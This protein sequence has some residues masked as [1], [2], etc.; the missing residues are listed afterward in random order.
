MDKSSLEEAF[1]I[2]MDSIMGSNIKPQDKIE[3]LM[4]LRNFLDPKDYKEN[5]TILDANK[6]SKKFGGR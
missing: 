3:L 4:N 6:R 5:I 1:N 2:I